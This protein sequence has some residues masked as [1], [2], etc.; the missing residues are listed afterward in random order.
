MASLVNRVASS[1]I[2]ADDPWAAVAEELQRMTVQVVGATGNRGAGVVWSS[3]GLIVTSA[4][5]ADGIPVI[6]LHDG[7]TYY[8]ERVRTDRYT[9]LVALH[10]PASGIVSAKLRDSRTLRVGE[11]V[12]AVGNP[13]GEAGAVSLGI[14]HTASPGTLIH[15]DIRLA[16]GNSG[17]PLADA[18]GYIVGI[19]CMVANGL[20]VAISTVAI[21]QF[22]RRG[23]SAVGE[24]G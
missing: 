4:H 11:L 24:A 9:D 12:V 17:G 5:V 2:P 7:R 19:N 18:A 16:P 10:I 22:L 1:C 21:Q 8:A 3:D 20:G 14:V 6:R 23:A 15:A 13:M